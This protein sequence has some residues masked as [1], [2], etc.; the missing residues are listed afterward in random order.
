MTKSLYVITSKDVIITSPW[1]IADGLKPHRI[2]IR[3]LGQIATVDE[4]NE[5]VVHDEVLTGNK[6]DSPTSVMETS[7]MSG[8]YTTDIED[9]IEVFADRAKRSLRR[10][11]VAKEVTYV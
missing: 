11:T 5:Y 7:F 2:V 6:T 9:A 4:I 8:Y 3:D 1:I 10:G